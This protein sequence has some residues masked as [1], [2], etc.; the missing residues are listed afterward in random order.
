ML[1]FRISSYIRSLKILA[2]AVKKTLIM[3]GTRP[4]PKRLARC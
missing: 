1:S 2:T 4:S 3:Y